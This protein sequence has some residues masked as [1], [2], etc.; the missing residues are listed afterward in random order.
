MAE[1]FQQIDDAISDGKEMLLNDRIND[2]IS[3]KQLRDE[4][5]QIVGPAGLDSRLFG[6]RAGWKAF[7]Q[8]FLK[9]LIDK[10]IIRT[11]LPSAKRLA[12]Q[13]MLEMPDFSDV[14]K[15]YLA[16]NAIHQGAVFWKILILPIG[17]MLTGPLANTEG[18]DD[19]ARD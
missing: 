2:I 10:P 14:D 18:P 1:F 11:K 17:Y 16:E 5:M 4:L 12:G 13:F 19:F 3:L 8:V 9:S 15:D 7:I 6:S